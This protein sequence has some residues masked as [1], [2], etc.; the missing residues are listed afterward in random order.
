VCSSEAVRKFFYELNK[1]DADV[2][3]REPMQMGVIA[4]SPSEV[5]ADTGKVKLLSISADWHHEG[6]LAYKTLYKNS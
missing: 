5:T 6:H 1:S 3:V 2:C 4:P